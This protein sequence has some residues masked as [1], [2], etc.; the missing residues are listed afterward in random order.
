MPNRPR[1]YTLCV[2]DFDLG[3]WFDEFGSYNYAEVKS[4]LDYHAAPARHKRI[5]YSDGTPADMITNRDALPHP[6]R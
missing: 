5:I 4:E 3:Q 1:Y 2:Y 6:K